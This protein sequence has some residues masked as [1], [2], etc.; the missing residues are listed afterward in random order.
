MNQCQCVTKSTLSWCSKR[1]L[2]STPQLESVACR[3]LICV[4]VPDLGLDVKRIG[5]SVRP[6]ALNADKSPAAMR[7]DGDYRDEPESFFPQSRRLTAVPRRTS[8]SW[9][10]SSPSV[11][12]AAKNLRIVAAG[13]SK[14]RSRTI[15]HG[16]CL[17]VDNRWKT[18][19]WRTEDRL[20]KVQKLRSRNGWG[21]R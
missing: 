13:G 1:R 3:R 18:R 9:F 7:H 6:A 15:W 16:L 8:A 11:R 10:D 4:S 20:R 5:P 14:G 17:V 19:G 2:S 12:V 21:Q